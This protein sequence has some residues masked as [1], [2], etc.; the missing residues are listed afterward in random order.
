MFVVNEFSVMSHVSLR[1]VS[2]IESCEFVK[3][4]PGAVYVSS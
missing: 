3:L 2:A 1:G 4:E